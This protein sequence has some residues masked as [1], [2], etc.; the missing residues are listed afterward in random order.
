VC[1]FSPCLI[2]RGGDG[3]WIPEQIHITIT[4]DPKVLTYIKMGE[5]YTAISSGEEMMRANLIKIHRFHHPLEKQLFCYADENSEFV[6][7]I[8]FGS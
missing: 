1:S 4:V 6:L 3:T 7:S 8:L 5:K 2:N